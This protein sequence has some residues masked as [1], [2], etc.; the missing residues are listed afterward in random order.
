MTELVMADNIVCHDG[1]SIE[2]NVIGSAD[3]GFLSYVKYAGAIKLLHHG[4]LISQK[5]IQD[6]QQHVYQTRGS[7]LINYEFNVHR[8]L[9]IG[10]ELETIFTWR[11][12]RES[13]KPI[14]LQYDKFL[15]LIEYP[16]RYR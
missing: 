7:P 4:K 6:I 5:R 14:N 1:W 13:S 15:Y 8:Q 10:D 9:E 11:E 16:L 2:R 12:P 3:S